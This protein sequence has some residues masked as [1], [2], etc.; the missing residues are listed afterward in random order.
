MLML[1][2]MLVLVLML[3]VVIGATFVLSDLCTVYDTDKLIKT[4]V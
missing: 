1:M 3:M 2:L 4:K